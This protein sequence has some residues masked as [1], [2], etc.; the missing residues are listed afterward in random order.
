MRKPPG[1]G[2]GITAL[3]TDGFAIDRVGNEGIE[4]DRLGIE[5]DRWGIE[6]DRLGI[7][8][9]GSVIVGSE[10]EAPLRVSKIAFR[11]FGKLK[12]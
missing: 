2:A 1:A 11:I 3:E 7:D 12:I 8:T 4:T 9:L 5:I 6:T 10:T